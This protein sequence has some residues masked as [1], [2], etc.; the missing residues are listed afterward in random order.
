MS[1]IID[2]FRD[3]VEKGAELHFAH[4]FLHFVSKIPFYTSII[5]LI[6]RWIEFLVPRSL[7]PFFLLILGLG[8]L[9]LAFGLSIIVKNYITYNYLFKGLPRSV[10]DIS[11]MLSRVE[12]IDLYTFRENLIDAAADWLYDEM[13]K[14][15]NIFGLLKLVTPPLFINIFLL[16]LALLYFIYALFPHV[17]LANLSPVY[18]LYAV[19]MLLLAFVLSYINIEILA[20]SERKS[21]NRRSKVDD[22]KKSCKVRKLFKQ[23]MMA[24]IGLSLLGLG[25]PVSFS[26]SLGPKV[27]IAFG[28]LLFSAPWDLLLYKPPKEVIQSVSPLES[29]A[30]VFMSSAGMIVEPKT[31]NNFGK[32]FVEV[33]KAGFKLAKLIP[34]QFSSNISRCSIAK[35]S[36]GNIAKN[37]TTRNKSQRKLIRNTIWSITYETLNRIR[38]DI[39]NMLRKYGYSIIEFVD[40]SKLA[41]II[42]GKTL[43]ELFTYYSIVESPTVVPDIG[44]AIQRSALLYKNEKLIDK[45]GTLA[46]EFPLIIPE[47][48]IIREETPIS[49]SLQQGAT[50]T[51]NQSIYIAIPVLIALNPWAE[52]EKISRFREMLE[53]AGPM[54]TVYRVRVCVREVRGNCA[55]GYKPGDCFVVERFYI[56]EVGKGICIHALSSMLTLLSPFLKGVSAKV[57]GIGEQDDVGYVQCPDPGKPYT[58]G[59]TVVFELRRE[60]IE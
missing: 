49:I 45:L 24:V 19:V 34:E 12:H 59:G 60:R 43:K 57:L 6:S 11:K 17:S 20:P 16:P 48:Y 23:E 18:F 25:I 30:I 54:S 33:C 51:V 50:Y 3:I 37:M 14:G 40:I 13:S 9:A 39:E 53:G 21:R 22:D 46:K 38:T 4:K 58:C 56:S 2:V 1:L 7:H 35:P 44:Q 8:L 32:G 15:L 10:N 47:I 55:M 52:P 42:D 5:I 36:I 28:L 41:R 26:T 31:S 27:L 29:V